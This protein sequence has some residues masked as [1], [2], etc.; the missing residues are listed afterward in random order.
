MTLFPKKPSFL[1]ISPDKSQGYT[2]FMS[3]ATPEKFPCVHDNAKMD[4]C[5]FSN[6]VHILRVAKEDFYFK[7]TLNSQ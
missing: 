7:V 2:G 1:I 5:F 6:F 4:Q 3:I